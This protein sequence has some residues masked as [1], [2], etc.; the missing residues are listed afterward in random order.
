MP[1]A[2]EELDAVVGRDRHV[3]EADIPRLSYGKACIREA[4]RL[5]PVA[6][7]NV[8]H[9]ALADATV[10]GY[11]VPAGSHV[12]LSRVGLGRNPRVW[13]HPLRFDPDRH[14]LTGDDVTLTENDLRFISFS[15]G[16]RGGVARHR[17]ERHA[18]GKAP[19]GVHLEQAARGGGHRPRRVQARHLHGHAA[20]AA[21]RAAA[22]G[23][24]LHTPST[25]PKY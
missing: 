19:S 23:A 20:A 18:L 14:L 12:L 3:Q 9:V 21:R 10:A 15:T 5:H 6:P 8:P 25:R 2:V 1:K 13:D 17:H 7:F 16:R 11:R 24:P 22:A 4:F